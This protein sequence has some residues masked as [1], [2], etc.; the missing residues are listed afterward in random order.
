MDLG[1]A[2]Y[3]QTDRRMLAVAALSEVL[4]L[5]SVASASSHSTGIY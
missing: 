5:E 3:R 1:P 4:G 2:L